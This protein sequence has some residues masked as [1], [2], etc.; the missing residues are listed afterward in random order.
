MQIIG[1]DSEDSSSLSTYLGGEMDA[2]V[3]AG[4]G[5][6]DHI[7]FRAKDP[8]LVMSRLKENGYECRERDIPSMNLFQVFVEDPNGITIELNYWGEEQVAA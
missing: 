2:D 7:A 8:D 5:A 4:S 3:V 6:L 1:V